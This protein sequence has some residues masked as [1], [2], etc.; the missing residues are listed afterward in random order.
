MDNGYTP[1]ELT[2]L[3]GLIDTYKRWSHFIGKDD[4]CYDHYH[5]SEWGKCLRKQQYLHYKQLGLIEVEYKPMNSKLLRLFDKGHNM[6]E[7]WSAYF[8]NIGGVLR[9]QWKCKNLLCNMFDDKG[10]LKN[11]L[12][13]PNIKKLFGDKRTRVYGSKEEYGVFRPEVCKCG[14]KD[15]EY[16]ELSVR[17]ESLNMSGHADLIVDC[18][19]LNVDRF[20]EVTSTFDLRF[21]P[22]DNKKIVIDMKSIGSNQWRCQ[23]ERK[24]PHKAYVIQLTIYAY[25]LNCEYG[26]LMYENKDNSQVKCFKVDKN[27][28]WWETIKWQA[29]TMVDM[30]EN[31]KLP[32][33]RPTTKSD[34]ECKGCSFKS[35]CHK[36]GV[37]KD[38]ELERK[39]KS[40]YK[41][42]L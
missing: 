23:L 22:T 34:F 32:P 38:S 3:T 1:K 30:V 13:N 11:N 25:I 10:Q 20:K 42:L 8:D 39:R 15:F 24:G 4:R 2:A 14:S 36:S 6:H 12:T 31:R 16:V 27:D 37:W 7:R 19:N 18:S 33:P 41:V 5:P 9:G 17:D 28:E 26:V 40:F 29:K 21:L 35:L